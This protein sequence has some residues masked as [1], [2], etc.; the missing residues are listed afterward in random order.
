MLLNKG[1]GQLGKLL[2]L[3]LIW[4]KALRSQKPNLVHSKLLH[5]K[6]CCSDCTLSQV[7]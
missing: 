2:R 4:L 5:S 3:L 6:L 1:T 7:Y